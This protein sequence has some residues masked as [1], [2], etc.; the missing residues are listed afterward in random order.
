MECFTKRRVG[1]EG[2]EGNEQKKMEENFLLKTNIM[3]CLS[4]T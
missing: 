1:E 2:I 4:K 3:P